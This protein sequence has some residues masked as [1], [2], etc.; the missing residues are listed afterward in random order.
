[1]ESG[2]I[3]K[4]LVSVQFDHVVSGPGTFTKL[5]YDHILYN[6]LRDWV[7]VSEDIQMPNNQ[8]TFKV[9]FP[10]L[11]R[12]L[13]KLRFIKGLFYYRTVRAV[14]KRHSC[15]TVYFNTSPV[16]SF[17]CALFG[18]IAADQAYFISDYNHMSMEGNEQAENRNIVGCLKKRLFLEMEKYTL[19]KAKSVVVNSSYLGK[20]VEN[21]YGIREDKVALLYKGVDLSQFKPTVRSWSLNEP[22]KVLFVKSDY[23][24]GGLD[25]LL[26]ALGRVS[27]PV[28]LTVVGPGP[29][30]YAD[31]T[32]L[33]RREGYK[34][35]LNFGGRL[36]REEMVHEFAKHHILCV[37]SRREALG[38]VF[39]EGLASGMPVI[40]TEVGGI[41]E[42]LDGGRAGWLVTPED[43]AELAKI[44]E[45][46]VTDER[47]RREKVNHGMKWVKA[48]SIQ[49]TISNFLS[50][51]QEGQAA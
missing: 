2:G 45:L 25:I 8:A 34:G 1:M 4:M 33:A 18:G 22:T 24:T 13:W 10:T 44:I 48:F 51:D 27:Y 26:S 23:I 19:R 49:S 36:A 42:V 6:K 40:G 7:F 39:L 47:S 30:H 38:V 28:R 9:R 14:L 17:Y 16:V 3:R 29:K 46:V 35:E 32:E 31:I 50:L 21:Q 43:A 12:P 41:P 5:I 20:L 11:I 15:S 37:P